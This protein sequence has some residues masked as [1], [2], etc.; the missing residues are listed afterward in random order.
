MSWELLPRET[1]Q[2][3][4]MSREVVVL[5]GGDHARVVAEL[6]REAGRSVLG[7]IGPSGDIPGVAHLGPD[8]ALADFDPEAIEVVNGIGSTADA[9]L[10]ARVHAEASASGLVFAS[11]V[12]PSAVI[13]PSAEL[14]PG[15]VVFAQAVVAAGARLEMDVLVNTAAVVEHDARIGAHSHVSPGAI[16]AGRVEVGERT[17]VGLGA[18]VIQGVRIGSDCTI[19]AGAVVLADVPDGSVAVGVPARSRR[20]S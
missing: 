13:A 19:G 16:L 10:R 1:M 5:G 17:H 12:A 4:T 20:R 14:A 8:A 3:V 2:P 11:V 6:L 18:R 9:D 7:W 15:C